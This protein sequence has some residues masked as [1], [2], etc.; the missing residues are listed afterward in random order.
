MRLLK[1]GI[2]KLTGGILE[3]YEDR[4]SEFSSIKTEYDAIRIVIYQP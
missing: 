2:E 3:R 1:D 4:K